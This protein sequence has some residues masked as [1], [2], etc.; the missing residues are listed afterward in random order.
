[1]LILMVIKTFDIH[2]SHVDADIDKSFDTHHS[3]V[4]T[5]ISKSFDT[6]IML[7]LIV[8]NHLALNILM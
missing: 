2:H 6:I 3:H 8:T 5:D 1:M 4:V 7:I